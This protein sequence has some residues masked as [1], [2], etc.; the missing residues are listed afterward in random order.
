MLG[1]FRADPYRS[2]SM[3]GNSA[4][5]TFL[6]I[7]NAK[8][9]SD[10]RWTFFGGDNSGVP[11]ASRTMITTVNGDVTALKNGDMVNSMNAIKN[12]YLDA[13]NL[14]PQLNVT[15]GGGANASGVFLEGVNG[16]AYFPDLLGADFAGNFQDTSNVL[17][18]TTE[19]FDLVRSSTSALGMPNYTLIGYAT[20]QQQGGS[21]T[22]SVTSSIPAVPEPS[23]YALMVAGL[24]VAGIAARRRAAK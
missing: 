23:T 9:A 4:F 1:D 18:G 15:L 2:W 13:A 7:Y 16:R 19:L 24:A 21:Y 12:I 17:G 22:F 10:M 8:G 14:N 5:D 11:A 3:A 20:F 6:N